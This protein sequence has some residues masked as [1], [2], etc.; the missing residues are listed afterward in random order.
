LFLKEEEKQSTDSKR[1]LRNKLTTEKR[2]SKN[3]KIKLGNKKERDQSWEEQEMWTLK[4]GG[5]A[6]WK[7]VRKGERDMEVESGKK[8][9][10]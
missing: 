5:I 3:L 10:N 9:M 2:K 4:Q 8:I 1:K 7:Q 6:I